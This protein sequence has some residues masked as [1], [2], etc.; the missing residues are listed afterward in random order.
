MI[1]RNS[2]SFFNCDYGPSHKDVKLLF[3][4]KYVHYYVIHDK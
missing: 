4:Q 1:A 3:H 2:T